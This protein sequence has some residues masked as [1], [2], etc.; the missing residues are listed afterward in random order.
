MVNKFKENIIEK[1]QK[2]LKNMEKIFEKY[3]NVS[4]KNFF[5]NKIRK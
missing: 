2:K 3:G 1:Y 5:I 4:I